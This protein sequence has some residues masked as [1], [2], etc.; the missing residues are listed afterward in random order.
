MACGSSNNDPQ[1]VAQHY[2]DA[3]ECLDV[4]FVCEALLNL[5][6]FYRSSLYLAQ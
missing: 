1:I 5:L 6:K 3:I 4:N 2:F